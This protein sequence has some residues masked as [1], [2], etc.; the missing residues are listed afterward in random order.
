MSCLGKV[1]NWVLNN[2]SDE[3]LGENNI[4]SETQICF[5]KKKKKQGH[6]TV[7]LFYER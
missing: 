6:Q 7:C 2:R 4:I 3:Y 5:K 1:F